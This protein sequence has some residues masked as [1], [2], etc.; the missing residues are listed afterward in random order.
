MNCS[1]HRAEKLLEHGM[2]VVERKL[3]KRLYGIAT[4]NQRQFD[5]MPERGTLDVAS[6]M[7]RLQEEYHAKGKVVYVFC[8]PS[9]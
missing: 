8:G 6:M 5:F 3:E 1:C 9:S 2:K 7:R 4:F